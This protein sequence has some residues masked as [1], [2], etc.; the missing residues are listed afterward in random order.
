MTSFVTVELSKLA[1]FVEHNMSYQPGKFQLSRMSGSN[2]T[3][4]WWKTPPPQCCTGREKLSALRV[5]LKIEHMIFLFCSIL[6]ARKYRS[7]CNFVLEK[8][9]SAIKSDFFSEFYSIPGGKYRTAMTCS[10]LETICL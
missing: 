9:F 10:L 7:R 2:F 5:K 8:V 1:Y 4:G 6:I 3:G